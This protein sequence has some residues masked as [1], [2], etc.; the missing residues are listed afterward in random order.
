MG[1]K[2]QKLEQKKFLKEN[3]LNWDYNFKVGNKLFKL[4]LKNIGIK[5]LTPGTKVIYELEQNFK[6]GNKRKF[7]SRSKLLKLEQHF[8]ISSKRNL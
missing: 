5:T 8:K 2:S 7:W 3:L 6:N 4:E 1:T